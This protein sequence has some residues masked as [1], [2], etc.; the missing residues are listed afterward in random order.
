MKKNNNAEESGLPF[1]EETEKQ[2]DNA[3]TGAPEDKGEEQSAEEVSSAHLSDAGAEGDAD[4]SDNKNKEL[5]IDLVASLK[6]GCEEKL[7]ERDAEIAR[8]KDQLLRLQADFDNARK[9]MLR[10]KL[11]AIELANKALLEELLPVLDHF[12]MAIKTATSMDQSDKN[13]SSLIAGF[14]LIHNQLLDVLARA[15]L[16]PFDMVGKAFDPAV[17]EAIAIMES[18]EHSDGIIVEQIRCG[19]NY[20]KKLLRAA[21]VVVAKSKEENNEKTHEEAAKE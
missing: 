10:D 4:A 19:Y 6:K 9:R 17:C 1:Q 8:L 14:Q 5:V 13:V 21:H 2:K 16:E 18:S 20:K 7:R 12:Q 15:G 3:E 11:E